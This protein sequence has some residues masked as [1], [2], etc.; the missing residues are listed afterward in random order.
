VAA[1]AGPDGSAS[2]RRERLP[3]TARVR[4]RSEYLA[5]QNRGRRVSGAQLL[6]FARAGAGRLGITVSR[7]VGGAVVR[8][9]VK[10]WVRDCFRRRRD[11]FPRGLDLVVVARPA[12]GASDHATVCRELTTL[13]RRLGG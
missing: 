11:D 6:L 2:R 5:I 13:A 7:K 8:N 10:R 9:R 12:A 3:R 4:L 1:A